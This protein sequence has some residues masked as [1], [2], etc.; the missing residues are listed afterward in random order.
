M[1]PK[2]SEQISAICHYRAELQFSWPY[3][4]TNSHHPSWMS[5]QRNSWNFSIYE[6]LGG[7]RTAL[8]WEI[9]HASYSFTISP[10]ISVKWFTCWLVGYAQTENTKKKK[11]KTEIILSEEDQRNERMETKEKRECVSE[12]GG[13]F[14]WENGVYTLKYTMILLKLHI[15]CRQL[16]VW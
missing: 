11:W 13:L 9:G 1:T 5:V 14:L 6:F 7:A 4:P 10:I 16:W 15:T 2:T 8:R 3:T 12:P